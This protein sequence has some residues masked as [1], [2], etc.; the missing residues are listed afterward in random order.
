M[1]VF[2]YPNYASS[3]YGLGAFIVGGGS[4]S[5]DS[6][7]PLRALL[8]DHS[9]FKLSVKLTFE[10]LPTYDFKF[11]QLTSDFQTMLDYDS[12]HSKKFQYQSLWQGRERSFLV[13]TNINRSINIQKKIDM[14]F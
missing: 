1:I 9:V 11:A 13:R 7:D 4:I 6:M 3:Q 14:Q 5:L 10:S 2:S 12:A 8:N